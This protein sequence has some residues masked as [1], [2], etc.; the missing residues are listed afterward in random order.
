ML[1]DCVVD[2][3]NVGLGLGLG[4]VVEIFFEAMMI[5]IESSCTSSE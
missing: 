3:F 2:R 4:V 5:G 1:M